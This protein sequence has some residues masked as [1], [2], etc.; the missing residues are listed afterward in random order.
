MS[1]T[2]EA[3]FLLSSSDPVFIRS[4]AG[5]PNLESAELYQTEPNGHKFAPG[6]VCV[7]TGLEDFA[8]F[9]GQEV[10]ITNL[11]ESDKYGRAY[12]IKG[13]INTFLNWVYERRLKKAPP[14]PTKQR[15]K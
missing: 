3:T 13:D 6:D 12:Y 9:N 15:G 10:T 7:L 14:K 11:R 8:E 5:N 1:K 2:Q 4:M